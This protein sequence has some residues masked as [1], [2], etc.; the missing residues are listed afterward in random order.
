MGWI[1]RGLAVLAGLAAAPAVAQQ[2]DL[3][4]LFETR[5]AQ[6]HGHAGDFARA[7]LT[8]GPEGVTG[9]RGRPLPGFLARHGGGVSA[10][11]ADALVAMFARQIAAGPVYRNRCTICHD[12]AYEFARLKLILHDGALFGRYSGREIGPFLD[13]HARLTTAEAAAMTDALTE[14]RRGGR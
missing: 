4:A 3:H 10:A 5:C 8:L 12:R 7:S 11:E 6:C 13:G 14:I 9:R 2:A 1:G